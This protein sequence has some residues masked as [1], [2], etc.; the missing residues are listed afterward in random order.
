[1]A[2]KATAKKPAAEQVLPKGYVPT[3][4]KVY[5]EEIVDCA[6]AHEAVLLHFSHAVP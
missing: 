1:M 6:E 4:K 5:R 2:K 3:L